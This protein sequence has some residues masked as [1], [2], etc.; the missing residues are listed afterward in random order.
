[1][2]DAPFESAVKDFYFTN[3]IARASKIMADCAAAYGAKETGAT[4][5]NG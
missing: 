4:G 5:T 2:D 3:P 1:M